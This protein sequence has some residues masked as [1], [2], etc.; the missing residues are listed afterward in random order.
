MHRLRCDARP[1]EA[2]QA[3]AGAGCN[4]LSQYSVE[5]FCA[6]QTY[7]KSKRML[8]VVAVCVGTAVIPVLTALA[9]DI[10]PLQHPEAGWDKNVSLWCRDFGMAFFTAIGGL[11]QL[12]AMAPTA[13]LTVRKII[14][15]GLPAAWCYTAILMLLAKL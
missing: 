8:H 15:I 5:R 10:L 12:R 14:R 13:D 7:T 2:G 3:E 1:R 9:L 4:P 6:L 11:L